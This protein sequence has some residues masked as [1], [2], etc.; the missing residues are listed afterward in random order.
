[1]VAPI[2]QMVAATNDM[3][4]IA[5]LFRSGCRRPRPTTAELRASRVPAIVIAGSLDASAAA[6][7]AMARELPGQLEVAVIPDANHTAAARHPDFAARLI[8]FLNEHP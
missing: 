4:A 1:M 8:R 3:K 5:A 6:G 7:A 2:A